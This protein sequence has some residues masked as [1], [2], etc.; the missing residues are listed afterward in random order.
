MKP[1]HDVR[2]GGCAVLALMGL[3]WAVAAQADIVVGRVG[4]KTSLVSKEYTATL[5]DSFDAYIDRVNKG[6]GVNGQKIKVLFQEDEFKPDKSLAGVKA[7]IENEGAIAIVTP[8]SAP[9]AITVVKDGILRRTNTPLIG[10]SMGVREILTAPNVFPARANY[11]DEIALMAR[12]LRQMGWNKVAYLHFN[13]GVGPQYVPVVTEALTKEGLALTSAQGYDVSQDPAQ[14]AELVKRAV[15]KVLEGKPSAVITFGVGEGAALAM[16]QLKE[17]SGNTVQR[18]TWSV[19]SAEALARALG[20]DARGIIVT[21]ATP[22]PFSQARRLSLDY[23]RDLKAFAP[24]A[25]PSYLGMEAYIAARVLVE[26]L[27]RAGPNPNGERLLRAL[28]SMQ[29]YDMGD[30]VVEY[31]PSAKRVDFSLD[32][33]MIGTEGKL[34]R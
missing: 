4:S 30:F 14:Q 7:L 11:H 31:S 9:V 29:R 15:S 21:Q 8:P 10:P 3:G 24:Q 19:N 5:A 18:Y 26:G 32:I 25:Q 20:K 34:V 22:N 28:E 2:R 1:F 6:G 27:R 16:R 23:Q 33:T 17:L 12:H 13:A